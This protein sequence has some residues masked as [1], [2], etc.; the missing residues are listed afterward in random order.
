[1]SPRDH[2]ILGGLAAAV[3]TPF[4]GVEALAFFLA[5]VLIDTDHYLDFVYH[6]GLEDISL[7][8]M[9]R[10]HN[11]LERYWNKPG[12]LSIEIFHTVEFLTC[13]FILSI[14]T[15]SEVVTVIFLGLVF[16]VLL[17]TVYLYR[18]GALFI[19]SYSMLEY[20]IRRHTLM[21]KGLHPVR[22][23]MDVARDVSRKNGKER[24][25]P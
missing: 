25:R 24:G 3:I 23:L 20:L 11:E 12:F 6:N 17:D 21:K 14:V 8:G 2:V 4:V 22:I 9:F 19:R 5:S 10:Y 1:M 16:H 18:R 15:G 7:K 13:V